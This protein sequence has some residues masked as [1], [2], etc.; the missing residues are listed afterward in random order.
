M[1][2]E[3]LDLANFFRSTSSLEEFFGDRYEKDLEDYAAAIS[4]PPNLRRLGL[5]FQENKQLEFVYPYADQLKEL[6]LCYV[7]LDTQDHCK[8][9]RKC[10]N[11]EIIVVRFYNSIKLN[12]L[13]LHILAMIL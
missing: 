10:H 4:L 9:I 7:G 12:L 2:W 8:L 6:D 1:E 5:G 13:T 11:L 3:L